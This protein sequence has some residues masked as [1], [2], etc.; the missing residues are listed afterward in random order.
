MCVCSNRE[1]ERVCVVERV[2]VA[3][4][5]SV[6][7]REREKGSLVEREIMCVVVESVCSRARECDN[8]KRIS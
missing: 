1:R 6:C 2:C 4:R 7:S 3:E 8:L 5:G